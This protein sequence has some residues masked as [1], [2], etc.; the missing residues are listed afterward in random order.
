MKIRF[1]EFNNK[2]RKPKRAYPSDTGLDCFMLEDGKINPHETLVIK[3]GFGIEIPNGYTARLQVRTSVAMNGIIVQGCAIDAG[4]KGE[5]HYIIHNVSNDIFTWKKDDR[6]CYIE[7]YPCV[8]PE[9]I[10]FIDSVG[11]ERNTNVIGSTG[12]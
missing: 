4:Y 5:I 7:V 11:I 9:L 1:Y 2:V 3:S 12:R 10:D 6:L 8:Y